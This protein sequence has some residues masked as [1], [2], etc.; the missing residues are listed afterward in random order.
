MAGVYSKFYVHVVFSPK[1]RA[2]VISPEWEER[3]YQYLCAIARNKTHKIITVNGMP[4]HIHLLIGFKPVTNISDLV[5]DLK[6]SSADFIND[7][8]R[9]PQKFQWQEGYG[10]FSVCYQHYK[11]TVAYI[12]GQKE[13]HRRQT[14]REEYVTM[15]KEHD[16]PFDERYLFE[17]FE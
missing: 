6:R 12:V 7:S 2:S 11:S 4:D 10:G 5:R 9:P 16:I 8:F 3:L 15:L 1:Y 14:F 13:H 17:W